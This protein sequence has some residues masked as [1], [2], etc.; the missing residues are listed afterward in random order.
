[1]FGD[2]AIVIG[3]HSGLI[4]ARVLSD[5]F[6]EVLVLEKDQPQQGIAARKGVPQG[7]HV[8]G[9]QGHALHLLNHYYPGIEADLIAAGAASLD[10]SKKIRM[11]L[12]NG[13]APP[14]PPGANGLSMTRPLLESLIR[15]HT[16]RRKDIRLLWNARVRNL[17]FDRGAVCG[18]EYTNGSSTPT[19][20]DAALVV[21]ASGRG[22]RLGQWLVGAGFRAPEVSSIHVDV[23]YATALYERPPREESEI[24][25]VIRHYPMDKLG[26]AMLPVENDQWL[27]S[28]SGRFGVYPGKDPVSFLESAAALPVPEIAETLKNAAATTGVSAYTFSHNEVRHFG[29]DL[30]AGILPVGDSV[31]SLNPLYGQGMTS[32]IVQADLLHQSLSA[33]ESS[34]FN[35][36]SLT[37]RH[38]PIISDFSAPP[39]KRAVLGDTIFSEASGDIPAELDA[40]RSEEKQLNARAATDPKVAN[41]IFQ[42]AQ[43][44]EPAEKLDALVEM[45]PVL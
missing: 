10:F 30:P 18:V 25:F 4:T 39:W 42:V 26:A 28:L 21:D 6:D 33:G 2:R 41:L 20:T 7:T 37:A 27:L 15:E 9:L 29:E 22:T 24:G 19:K 13:W 3:G 8:H 45:Q 32:A 14:A 11:Y 16:T 36:A 5:F 1:V 44:A 35:A 43:F 38:L 34:R 12:A 31:I 17:L 40:W 23:R